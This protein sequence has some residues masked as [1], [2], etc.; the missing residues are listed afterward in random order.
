MAALPEPPSEHDDGRRQA[1]R[2]LALIDHWARLAVDRSW[3]YVP[4]WAI[5]IGGAN[6]VL[7]LLLND[8]STA[9]NAGLAILYAA[10]FSVFAWWYTTQRTHRLQPQ[11]QP[12]A[13][14]AGKEGCGAGWRSGM[15]VH[16][17]SASRGP[18]SGRRW[19]CPHLVVASAGPARRRPLPSS[20]QG[21]RVVLAAVAATTITVALLVAA[22]AT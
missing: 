20:Q 13:R 9:H 1:G 15:P 14:P 19:S 2:P 5:G 11:P 16:R 7:R 3:P 8:A 10:G 17:S 21:R 12:L 22:T 6:F 18:R 4:T